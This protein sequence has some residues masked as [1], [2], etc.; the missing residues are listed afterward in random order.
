MAD[1]LTNV[2]PTLIAKL[3]QVY[4]AMSAIGF[5]M[6]PVSGVR[7]TGQQVL[8]YAKGRYG[9][10]G[11]IVTNCDG[12]HTKSNHQ[13]KA[14]GLGYAVDSAFQG[15]DAYLERD[16]R[17]DRIWAA[18]CACVEAVGLR[19]GGHFPTVDRPHAELPE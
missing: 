6:K 16:P 19:S 8:E 15:P 1:T 7:T 17:G 3:Q 11:R 5:P 13:V 18:F 9:N 10:A 4:A 14:D 2:H 12:V